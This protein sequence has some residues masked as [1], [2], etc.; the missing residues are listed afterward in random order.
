ML[1][2]R[3]STGL[4]V[5]KKVK[6]VLFGLLAGELKQSSPTIWHSRVVILSSTNLLGV[7]KSSFHRFSTEFSSVF[8]RSSLT[9]VRIPLRVLPPTRAR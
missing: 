5:G 7:L 8:F 4:V 9:D 6:G 1:S 2:S 3:A